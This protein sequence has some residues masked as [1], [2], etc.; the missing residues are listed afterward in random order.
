MAKLTVQPTA[1]SATGDSLIHVVTDPSGVPLSQKIT[2]DNFIDKA[3]ILSD[4]L[5]YKTGTITTSTV[6]PTKNTYHLID[7]SAGE[8]NITLDAVTAGD[9]HWHSFTLESNSHHCNISVD[10]GI[11]TIQEA[12]T[13]SL[14]TE[15]A[16]VIIKANGIDGYDVIHDSR[17]YD[18][19]ISVTENLILTGGFESGALYTGD[20]GDAIDVIITIANWSIEHKGDYATFTKTSGSNSSIRVISA[21]LTFDEIILESNSGFTISAT[22]TGY[23]IKQDSRPDPSNITINFYPTDVAS[24]LEPTYAGTMVTSVPSEVVVTTPAITSADTENPT[25]LGYF[26]NDNKALIG[27]LAARNINGLAQVKLTSA[28]NRSIKIRFSYFEYDYGTDTLNTT[29]LSTTSYS[30]FITSTTAEQ[31]FIG[32]SLPE[33]TWAVTSIAGKTLVAGLYAIKSTASGDNPTLDFI[34][35]GSTPSKTTIDVPV[36]SVNHATLGGVSTAGTSVP[37]GHIDNSAPFQLP[38]LTTVD[39]DAYATPNNGMIIMN[40][41]TGVLNVYLS[42][43]WGVM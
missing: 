26:I 32:G 43:A 25:F 3:A 9:V 31:R 12:T 30:T 18:R 33:N 24:T 2:K 36:A 29:P 6:S 28:F 38:E 14:S 19:I 35:G 15:L 22:S 41:T 8:V 39:R 13:I 10:G 4:D 37:D 40:T 20:L 16:Q 17:E 21:D 42:G 23:N 11:Q 5:V 7:S 27:L 1:T 34:S